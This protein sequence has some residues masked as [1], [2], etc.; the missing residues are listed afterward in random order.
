MTDINNLS[1]TIVAKS[2]QLNA[3]DLVGGPITVQITAVKAGTTAEQPVAVHISG[4]HQPW[5]PCKTMRRV[6]VACWGQN[7]NDWVGKSMRLHRDPDVIYGGVAV[8]GIRVSAMSD[9]DNDI[10]LMLQAKRGKKA[11]VKISKLAMPV[12][13]AI[14]L[15]TDE[16]I[17]ENSPAWIAAIQ[18]GKIVPSNI[19]GKIQRTHALTQAQIDAINAL[20]Q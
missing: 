8:G 6:L 11:A 5:Y 13:P 4:G 7:G 3:D 10:A 16:Q 1:T 14:P 18:A 17:A 2:D 19:I 9:I 20:Q 15:Y 12:A